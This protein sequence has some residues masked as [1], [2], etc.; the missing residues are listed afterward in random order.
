MKQ[1]FEEALELLRQHQPF[2]I[3]TVVRV[4]GSTPQ[5]PGAKMLIRSNGT[6]LGTL[7]G[8]CVEGDI[9]YHATRMLKEG[10]SV[11]FHRYTLTEKM[12]ARDGLVC[13]GT[14]FFFLQAFYDEDRWLPRVERILHAYQGE[15]PI[16]LATLM[17]AADN[18]IA[19]GMQLFI[20]E[21]GKLDGSSR[22]AELDRELSKIGSRLAAQ[23]ET[24]YLTWEDGREYFI[25]GITAPPLL[26]IMGGGHVGKA[27]SQLAATVGFRI[28]VID[29]REEFADCQRFPEAEETIV[30]DFGEGLDRVRINANTF[31]LIA[32]RG[33]RFD[34]L[35]LEAALHT[36]ARYIGLL[37]SQRKV[38][39]IYKRLLQNGMSVDNFQRV[40]APIGLNIGALSPEELAVSI[41]GEMIAVRRGK[42]GGFLTIP[43]ETIRRLSGKQQVDG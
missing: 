41:V 40:H 18:E 25:E 35:A 28:I 19:S 20:S 6:T 15:A 11:H 39:M 17:N 4:K 36:P 14:M 16:A 29:D 26:I 38:F 2:V 5:K 23:G 21:E 22:N 8:G 1:I 43:V 27:V 10:E 42:S 31:I 34:D 3:A 30:A 24:H 32:T 37:G 33:H 9:Y 7:G 12:A 13:G